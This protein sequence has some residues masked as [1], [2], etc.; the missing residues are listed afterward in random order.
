MSMLGFSSNSRWWN[1]DG[2][3]IWYVIYI[4]FLRYQTSSKYNFTFV[5]GETLFFKCP[6]NFYFYVSFQIIFVNCPVHFCF[7]K[8]P[9][10]VRRRAVTYLSAVLSYVSAPC[11]H[12]S[13]C[14]CSVLSR[15][16][17]LNYLVN[18]LR[19]RTINC[20]VNKHSL[21]FVPSP[22]GLPILNCW[23][24]RKKSNKC[25]EV[26]GLSSHFKAC[27]ASVAMLAV[28]FL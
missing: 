24:N 6:F 20:F 2:I 13:A 28:N 19:N 10:N 9:L 7:L 3:V 15:V 5:S 23:T 18:F 1:S 22:P 12:M 17:L 8:C 14:P 21:S 27:S 26:V 11:C 25:F 4:L 16:P